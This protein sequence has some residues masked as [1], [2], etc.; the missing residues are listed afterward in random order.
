MVARDCEH[1]IHPV[2]VLKECEL[3]ARLTKPLC[4]VPMYLS[5]PANFL[6]T[7]LCKT[8]VVVRRIDK[9]ILDIESSLP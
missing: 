1:V 2:N 6:S 8:P 4:Q 7:V 5:P 3:G 9:A